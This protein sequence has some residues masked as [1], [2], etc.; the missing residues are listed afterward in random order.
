[1]SKLRVL[2]STILI[3]TLLMGCN[4][5]D[6]NVHT[7]NVKEEISV[8][9]NI[10]NE[11]D[12]IKYLVEPQFKI[13]FPY[14]IDG[15][16]AV[17]KETEDGIK[18][19]YINEKGETIVPAI[20]DDIINW[21][22]VSGEGSL[23]F[24]EGLA[25]VRRGEKWGYVNLQGEEVIDFIYDDAYEFEENS[26]IIR[27]EDKYGCINKN[28]ELIIPV[29]YDELRNFN[30]VL[31]AGLEGKWGFIKNDGKWIVEP[32]VGDIQHILRDKEHVTVHSGDLE[33]I[34]KIQNGE[35]IRIAEPKYNRIRPVRYGDYDEYRFTL[36][37]K[38]KDEGYINPSSGYLD[39]KGN[40]LIRS[41]KHFYSELSEGMRRVKN[42]EDKWGYCDRNN[43]IV[44]PFQYDEAESFYNGS[45]IVTVDEKKGFIDKDGKWI[46]EPQ[47]ESVQLMEMNGYYIAEDDEGQCLLDVSNLD[48]ISKKYDSIEP[49]C[50]TNLVPVIEEDKL[51]FI[52]IKGEEIIKP[53]Y[54]SENYSFSKECMAVSQNNQMFY[55]DE[56]G[57]RIGDLVF[58]D[59]NSFTNGLA[60]VKLDGKW[61]VVDRTG[62][63]VVPCIFE[64]VYVYRNGL[65]RVSKNGKDGLISLN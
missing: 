14:F 51:G 33:G 7:T 5:I 8:N 1:M 16:I 6:N 62:E 2:S 12:K 17:E 44:I 60:E 3:L 40:E 32:N 30:G 47:Y 34:Y 36:F 58:E 10:Q 24:S 38:D 41:Q 55:I 46:L 15:I 49:F 25:P 31:I 64:E 28:G 50:S 23:G 27:I 52:N 42:D 4:R 48:K 19:G 11:I 13:G 59:A 37:E 53:E 18:Y 22:S 45:A 43:N 65:A 26:A 56:E 9:T 39:E 61:G 20:Y 57:E 63:I 35:I 21:V 29:K 54:D